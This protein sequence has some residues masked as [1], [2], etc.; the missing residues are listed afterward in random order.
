MNDKN[1]ALKALEM[2]GKDHSGFN[3]HKSL[4]LVGPEHKATIK[5]LNSIGT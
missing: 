5:K 3:Y 2:A 4:G 1:E